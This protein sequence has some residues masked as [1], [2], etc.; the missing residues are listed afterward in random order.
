MAR[1]PYHDFARVYDDWQKLYPRPFSLAMAPKVIEALRKYGVPCPVLA[2][3]ACG[4]GTFAAWWSR[5][6]PAWTVFGLD[7]SPAM[8]RRARR[9]LRGSDP[10][11][12]RRS[13]GPR[14]RRS[15]PVFRVQSLRDLSLPRPAG[16]LT[17][18]FDS[19]NHITRRPE[20]GRIFHQARAALAPGGLFL[21]DLVDDRG[22]REVFT[23]MSV[24]RDRD[25]YVGLET[26]FRT[27]RGVGY[28]RAHFSF[29]RR[30]GRGWSRTEFRIRERRWLQ[31]EVRSLVQAAGLRCLRVL[32]LDPYE[33]DDFLVPRTFWICR[34]P[35][36]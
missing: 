12:G 11:A 8:I 19:L 34:R 35:L 17:C 6:H 14:S 13:A 18:L 15:S 21:F 5:T 29:F 30:R 7:Q 4:T 2:D 28:G 22:F 26:E 10:P 9:S 23:G 24:L 1:D 32:R 20:M 36:D 31:S 16:V 3:L 33:S 27:V 25:L